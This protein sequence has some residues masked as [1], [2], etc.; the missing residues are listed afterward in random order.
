MQRE[1]L[2]SMGGM[3]CKGRI[4]RNQQC[5]VWMLWP[6]CRAW[7]SQNKQTKPTPA[8]SN[9]AIIHDERLVRPITT[10][11]PPWTLVTGG[12]TSGFWKTEGP[13]WRLIFNSL[14]TA[15]CCQNDK[16]LWKD[17]ALSRSW[18]VKWEVKSSISIYGVMYTGSV[19][20]IHTS[21]IWKN[22]ME[23]N[24]AIII[25]KKGLA[26]VIASISPK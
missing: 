1:G 5:S 11:K 14:K 9:Y 24:W 18:I 21:F 22:R 12:F 6:I 3:T 2:F 4:G 19:K 10:Y 26:E 23:S 16:A 7:S 25:P 13:K 20:C 8:N 17:F 15:A